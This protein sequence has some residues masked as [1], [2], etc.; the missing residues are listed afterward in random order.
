MPTVLLKNVISTKPTVFSLNTYCDTVDVYPASITIPIQ[1]T[2]QQDIDATAGTIS[3]GIAISVLSDG[4]NGKIAVV[5]NW[6]GTPPTI[7]LTQVGK[8]TLNLPLQSHANGI[9]GPYTI[10]V[11]ATDSAGGTKQLL[12]TGT[13]NITPSAG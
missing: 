6:I 8:L 1:D 11:T 5:E 4:N 2:L 12:A 9:V 13:F 10:S 3:G 7:D